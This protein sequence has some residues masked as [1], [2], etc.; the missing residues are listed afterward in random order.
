MLIGLVILLIIVVSSIIFFGGNDEETA[1][2]QVDDKEKIQENVK[3]KD[4]DTELGNKTENR[5]DNE[6]QEE[7]EKEKEKETS[8]KQP[9]E[10]TK[11]NDNKSKPVIQAPASEKEEDAVVTNGGESEDVNKTIENSSWQPIGTSQVGEHVS[12]Y[13]EDSVDWSEMT[14]AISYATGIDQDNMTVW[15]LG[16]NGQNKSVGTVSAKNQKQKYRVYIDWVD[17]QGWK[18]TKVEE[19]N[20]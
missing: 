6:E 12:V 2:K 19:I 14:Q 13:E 3:T 7:K 9:K 1:G 10:A 18:P 16:N 4:E 17:G 15:F 8:E 20:K 11:K 5:S